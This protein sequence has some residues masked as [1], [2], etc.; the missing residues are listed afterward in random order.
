MRSAKKQTVNMNFSGR[1]KETVILPIDERTNDINYKQIQA[2]LKSGFSLG[3]EAVIINTKGWHI[4]DV[5]SEDII[6]FLKE[7]KVHP[8]CEHDKAAIIKYYQAIAKKYSSSDVSFISS[9]EKDEIFNKE[10]DLR[11]Q[12]RSTGEFRKIEPDTEAFYKLSRNRLASKGDE[13]HGLTNTQIGEAKNLHQKE[14]PEKSISDNYYRR[15]RNKPLLMLHHL[16]LKEKDQKIYT[17]ES[18]SGFGVSFP[19][20]HYEKPVEVVVNKVWMDIMHENDFVE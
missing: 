18:V 17:P 19:Y 13:K 11:R 16:E 14:Y 7:F 5:P 1:I 15:V 2:Q 10:F 20:G 3:N 6:N 9:N 4:N 8:V 12:R